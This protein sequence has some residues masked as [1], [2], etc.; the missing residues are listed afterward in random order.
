MNVNEQEK[1]MKSASTNAAVYTPIRKARLTGSL[2]RAW[3]LNGFSRFAVWRI[4]GGL[5]GSICGFTPTSLIVAGAPMVKIEFDNFK[6][7]YD[8]WQEV[9]SKNRIIRENHSDLP[10]RIPTI[11]NESKRR[12]LS[13]F[14]N[15]T[16]EN[17]TTCCSTRLKR[18]FLPVQY[19][20]E[21]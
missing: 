17:G 21:E 12:S 6:R 4:D 16:T 2:M 10:L 15:R 13:S 3:S 1:R 20:N 19:A 14:E 11:G 18:S 7:G 8:S 5:R 9:V